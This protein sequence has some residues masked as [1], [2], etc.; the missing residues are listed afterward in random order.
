MRI[1]ERWL[2]LP[3]S[4]RELLSRHRWDFAFAEP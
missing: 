2:D 4:T 1:V 3:G